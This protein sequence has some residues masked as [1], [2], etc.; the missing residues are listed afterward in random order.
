MFVFVNVAPVRF[1]FVRF[2]PAM[3]RPVNS[4]D[5]NAAPERSTFGPT[6]KLLRITYELDGRVAR[7]ALVRL[8]ETKFDTVAPVRVVP[9]ISHP[10]I[11]MPDRSVLDRFALRNI[12]AGPTM[13]PFRATYPVGSVAVAAPTRFP[14]IILVIVALV[15]TAFVNVDPV[16]VTPDKSIPVAAALVRL[17]LG[18]TINPLR[19]K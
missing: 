17:T 18:P 7:V 9:D 13:N 2:A 1:A 8:P 11:D 15:S 6:M 16:M 3:V 10:A 4:C 12:T 5:D 14:V 19:I